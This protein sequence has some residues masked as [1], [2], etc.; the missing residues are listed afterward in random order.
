MDET[1][2]GYINTAFSPEI[3]ALIFKSFDIYEKFDYT[4]VE[5]DFIDLIMDASNMHSEDL[6]DKFI[7]LINEKLDYIVGQHKI[8]LSKDTTLS[9]RIEFCEGLYRLQYMEDYTGISNA[10][11]SLEPND[12][13]LALI[14]SDVTSLT[15]IEIREIIE[16][17]NP[18]VLAS[19]KSFIATKDKEEIKVE[20]TDL[21][22]RIKYFFH[23]FERNSIGRNLVSVVLIGQRFS[24]YLPFVKEEIIKG[25]DED[26]AFNLYSVLILSIDGYNNPLVV[27]RKY[28]EELFTNINKI[29]L[30]EEFMI[31]FINQFNEFMKVQNEKNR[32]S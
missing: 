16:D 30:I 25:S 31:K 18:I 13:I 21:A 5:E 9:Q 2:A 24:E 11:E 19:L 27:Y 14:M 3:Q 29:S 15:D 6:H 10:L 8:T 26:I 22:T 32:I 7:I 17:F 4:N 23:L 20:N 12:E 1:I 28:A